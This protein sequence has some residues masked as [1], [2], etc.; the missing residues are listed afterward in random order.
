MPDCPRRI[1]L[2]MNK[3]MMRWV[4]LVG[5]IAAFIDCLIGKAVRQ[6]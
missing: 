3:T 5:V 2:R 6:Q 1:V 4:L